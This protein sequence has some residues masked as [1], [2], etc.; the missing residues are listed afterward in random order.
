MIS[1]YSDSTRCS[2]AS[3]SEEPPDGPAALPRSAS[4]SSGR[5]VHVTPT[6]GWSP[7]S[8]TGGAPAGR[9]GDRPAPRPRVVEHLADV[10]RVHAVDART[11]PPR[12]RSAASAGPIRG[13]RALARPRRA[14][15]SVSTCSWRR[16]RAIPR[17][18]Q[19]LDGGAEPDG[20]GDHRGAGLEPLRRRGVRRR[21]H[22]HDLDHRATGVQRRHGLEQLAARPQRAD[23][24]R[25]EHLVAGEHGSVHAERRQVDRQVR[26]AL[27]RV[28]HHEGTDRAGRG[29]DRR[30]VGHRAG[31]VRHVGHR[32]DLG[33]LGH[34]GSKLIQT[35][36]T[37]VSH[38]DP[39]QRG[40]RPRDTAPATG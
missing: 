14:A 33:A 2:A 6:P 13:P 34:D 9:S 23:P 31:D 22:G 40:A 38:A 15:R 35:Q 32:D 29:D 5:R 25:S 8:R 37:V 3:P 19:V 1:W 21:V 10:V 4:T 24:G 30:H 26:H 39:A 17:S 16:P 12:R 36:P 11:T 18:P 7:A 28:E 20:L 27:A